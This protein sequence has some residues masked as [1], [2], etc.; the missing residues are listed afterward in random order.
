MMEMESADKNPEKKVEPKKLSLEE[1]ADTPELQE[2]L[3]ELKKEAKRIEQELF[4]AFPIARARE[5]LDVSTSEKILKELVSLAKRSSALADQHRDFNVGA[6]MLC[7]RDITSQN[8]NPWLIRFNAN[9]KPV[10]T[11]KKWC[12]EQYLMDDLETRDLGIQR[13]LS[14]VIVGKPQT[15][16]DSKIHQITLTP[17]K[18]CR[19]RMLAL[20]EAEEPK[21]SY[22]TEIIT[23]DIRDTR[24]QKFQKVKDLPRFHKEGTADLVA[25]NSYGRGGVYKDNEDSDDL[26]DNELD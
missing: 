14:M 2:E 21:I 25:T 15:D 19:D 4:N 7:T 24:Y 22:E 10:S 3:R 5:M 12:A 23:A 18:L 17:C 6:V 26:K 20:A 9:T 16:D 1:R 8:G 13:V 11:D